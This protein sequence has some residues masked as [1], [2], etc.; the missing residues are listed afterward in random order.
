MPDS[1]QPFGRRV[2]GLDVADVVDQDEALLQTLNGRQQQSPGAQE[3]GS[4]AIEGSAQDANLVLGSHGGDLVEVAALDAL[5]DGGEQ[6]D[7][8]SDDVGGPQTD[9]Y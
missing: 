1:Q 8:A 2:H 5:H 6:T 4:H 7:W 3:T 9:E